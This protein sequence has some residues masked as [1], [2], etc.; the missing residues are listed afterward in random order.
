MKARLNLNIDKTL[1]T[2]IQSYSDEKKISISELVEQYFLSILKPNRQPNIIGMVKK[3]NPP[4]IQGNLDLKDGF[5]ED[6]ANK[7]GF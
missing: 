5:Y 7:Y 4:K 6:Q 2:R 3:L 1:L